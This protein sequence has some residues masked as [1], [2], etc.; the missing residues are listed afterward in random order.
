[1]ERG[2]FAGLGIRTREQFQGFVA[3]IVSNPATPKRYAADGTTFYIDD[4]SRTVVI[5]GQGGEATAFRPDYGVG[6]DFYLSTK[7]PKNV[8]SPAFDPVSKGRY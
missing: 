8:N 5:R 1:V 3:D 2:E 4:A 6:W 7:V